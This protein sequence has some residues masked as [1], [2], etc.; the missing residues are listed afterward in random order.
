MPGG[1]CYKLELLNELIKFVK[2]SKI[3]T[4]YGFKLLKIGDKPP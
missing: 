2:Y 1:F 4:N 3:P